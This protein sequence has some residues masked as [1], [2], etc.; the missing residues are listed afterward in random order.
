M[1][2]QPAKKAVKLCS[3]LVFFLV[4]GC[5]A[6]DPYFTVQLLGPVVPHGLREGY[7][8][9][10]FILEHGEELQRLPPDKAMD[11]IYLQALMETNGDKG[12]AYLAT[13]IAVFEHRNIPIS[14]LGISLPLTLEDDSVFHKRHDYLPK[15]LYGEGQDDRDK[16]QHFFANSWLKKELG[17]EWLVRLIGEFIE[18]GED[19]V[20]VGGVYDERDKRANADGIRF[21][22]KSADSLEAVPSNYIRHRSPVK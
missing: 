20:V 14:G 16:L 21:G 18:V 9:R 22:A 13:M 19:A 3:V 1:L 4:A 10:E 2:S 17:M 12:A 6:R 7:E 8:V 5:S 11:Q 15:N